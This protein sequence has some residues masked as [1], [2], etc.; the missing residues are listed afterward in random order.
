[1]IELTVPVEK[2]PF[3]RSIEG[4][5]FRDGKW[6]F[7][8]TAKESLIKCGLLDSNYHVDEKIYKEYELS[9]FLY[10]YQREVVNK[11]LN[12]DGYGLF[13]D[14]GCGKT[15]CGLEIAAHIGKTL[16]LCPLSII[17]TAWIEDCN[18]FYPNKKIVNC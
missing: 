5:K 15:I 14:T 6:L 18:K 7:P 10:K 17:E 13:L 8:E 4:R 9:D 3:I 1:M 12:E 11:A 2:I 16:V